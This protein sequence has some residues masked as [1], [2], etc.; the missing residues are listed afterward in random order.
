MRVDSNLQQAAIEAVRR[1]AQST[2][3]D[4]GALLETARRESGLDRNAKAATSSAAGLFQ[5]IEGTWLGLV[6]RY[7][8]K[9]GLAPAKDAAGRKALLDLRYDPDLAAKMAGELTRENS[10]TLERKLGRAPSSG[11]LYA[12]H[13]LGPDGAARL[14]EADP[15][16]SAAALFPKAAAANR[17]L[18]YD[19]AGAP[20]NAATLLA[21]LD[22]APGASVAPAARP[23]SAVLAAPPVGAAL[24]ALGETLGFD[25]WSIA[26]RAYRRNEP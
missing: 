23:P 26:M 11:E 19:R 2:G 17:S 21:K 9:Y 24:T 8:G 3:V 5:F 25:L 18:F 14:I 7:G 22:L 6:D 16:A 1:A 15:G 10:A 20:V 12:A 4:F 13:V